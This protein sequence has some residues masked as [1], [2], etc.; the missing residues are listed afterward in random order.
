MREINSPRHNNQ[1]CYCIA[2]NF[3][4]M[5]FFVIFVADLALMT[6]NTR[7]HTLIRMR[8][9]MAVTKINTTKINSEGL[10]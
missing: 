6:T 1:N 10:F 2:G 4:G 5:L 9:C 3:R 8:W 7:T